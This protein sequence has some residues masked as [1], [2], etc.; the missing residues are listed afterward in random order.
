MKLTHHQ[1]AAMAADIIENMRDSYKEH[2]EE[3][4][5]DWE[6]GE[7]HLRDDASI[8]ELLVDLKKWVPTK[9][10]ASYL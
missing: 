4:C 2:G 3:D 10:L 7:R 1:R 5:G 6:D 8:S 9:P